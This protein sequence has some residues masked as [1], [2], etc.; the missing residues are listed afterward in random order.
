MTTHGRSGLQR[1]VLGSVA[2]RMLR[3]TDLPLL[4]IHPQLHELPSMSLTRETDVEQW[5][6]SDR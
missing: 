1:W 2:E 6:I 3:Q 4:L 5:R